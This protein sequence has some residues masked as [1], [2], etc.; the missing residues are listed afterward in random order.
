MQERRATDKRIERIE[1]KVDDMH[2]ILVGNGS[3]GLC[4]KTSLMW[5]IGGC[6]LAGIGIMVGKLLWQMLVT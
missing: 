6:F 4:A 1:I 5:R 2:R 3:I